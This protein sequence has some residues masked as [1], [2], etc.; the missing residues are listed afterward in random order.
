[1]INYLDQTSLILSLKPVECMLLT[2]SISGSNFETLKII[3]KIQLHVRE[4]VPYNMNRDLIYK[5]IFASVK[6]K[7]NRLKF[8]F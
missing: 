6:E 7:M 5:N 2:F 1:M 3:L 4:I 8:Y